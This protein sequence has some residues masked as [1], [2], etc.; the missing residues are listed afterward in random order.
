MNELQKKLLDMFAWFHNLC[1]ENNLTYYAIGGTALGAVRH[2][3]FIPWDDDIDVGM[4]RED[5]EKLLC[6]SESINKNNK[7]LFEFPNKINKE[8][9]Y[10]YTKL[11][12]STTTLIER[13]KIKVKR[14]IFIDIFPIDGIGNT[15][16][17]ALLNFKKIDS[18]YNLYSARTCALRKG[19]AWYKNLSITLFRLI[20]ELIWDSYK[21]IEQIDYMSKKNKYEESEYVANICGAWHEKE[22]MKKEWLGKPALHKFEDIEMF[23]PEKYDLYLT[24]LYGNY[25]Q[26]PPVEKRISHHDYELIDLNNPYI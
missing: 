19:R 5:Y 1:V 11:Y 21:I 3:G 22:I 15:E 24:K 25:M 6:L 26:L 16:Q 2:K 4:P 20:P 12:D 10:P 14:G 13:K 17:E 7:F 18:K 9:Q 23:C 8:Y